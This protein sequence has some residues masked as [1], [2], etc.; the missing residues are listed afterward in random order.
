[1]SRPIIFFGTS[2]FAVP[3]LNTLAHDAR[4]S[5]TLVVTQ[6][7][8]PVGRKQIITPTAVK[9]A[10]LVLGLPVF[11]PEKMKS[12]EA[13][14]TLQSYTFDAAVVASYGQILPQRILDLAPNRF[15]NLHG[16]ILPAYRGASPIAEAIKNGDT[17]TGNTVMIMDAGM[18]HGPTLATM[19][20]SIN[21]RDTTETLTEKLAQLGA[22]RFCEL[23][24]A[25]LDGNITPQEQ[26]HERATICKPIKKEQ[27]LVNPLT[28]TAQ[29]IERLTRAYTPW[30]LT[31]M[32]LGGVSLKLI[33]VIVQTSSETSS[34][35]FWLEKGALLLACA[36]NTILELTQVRPEG[37][38]TMTGAAF[39]H[40]YGSKQ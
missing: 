30:P 38:K 31:Q 12:D 15:V 26:D 18:D 20:V 34:G 13:L 39:F 8:R 25:Y 16:S 6:P 36:N 32:V 17:E 11:Q 23:F 29:E 10:A 22:E 7:D 35:T 14:A 9:T 2:S 33:E 1:M 24:A 27:A 40:G 4:F 19:H 37:G 21:S 5:I 28:Q 3:L